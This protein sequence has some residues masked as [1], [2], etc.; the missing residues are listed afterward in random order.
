M[1]AV[2]NPFQTQ[3]VAALGGFLSNWWGHAG[4]LLPKRQAVRSI[5]ISIISSSITDLIRPEAPAA[6][7]AMSEEEQLQDRFLVRP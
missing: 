2:Q 6:V 4:E 3:E 5:G 1:K 7:Q